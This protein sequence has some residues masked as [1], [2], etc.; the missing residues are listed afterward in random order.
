[1]QSFGKLDKNRDF[2]SLFICLGKIGIR[3]FIGTG[4]TGK[5]FSFLSL[6][7][8]K[9]A[10]QATFTMGSRKKLSDHVLVLVVAAELGALLA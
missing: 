3:P 4:K 1:M 8:V 10:R 2:G 5:I 9:T 7:Q 6:C